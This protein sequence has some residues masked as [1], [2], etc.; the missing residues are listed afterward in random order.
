MKMIYLE[1][2]GLP[3]LSVYLHA[4]PSLLLGTTRFSVH[5]P[6]EEFR[7]LPDRHACEAFV[8]ALTN[9]IGFEITAAW[10]KTIA[11]AREGR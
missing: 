9:Q 7:R 5:V 2:P 4:E 11:Q 10:E 8:E 1:V 3:R 6:D